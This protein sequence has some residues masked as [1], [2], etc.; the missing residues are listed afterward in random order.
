[1]VVNHRHLVITGPHR[2]TKLLQNL[3]SE[4]LIASITSYFILVILIIAM[5][6][7]KAHHVYIVIYRGDKHLAIKDNYK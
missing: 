6:I 7:S 5:V 4:S 2:Q 3:Q 1:M